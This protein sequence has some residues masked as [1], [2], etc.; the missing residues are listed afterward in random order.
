M[1]RERGETLNSNVPGA[2]DG[3]TT[4]AQIKQIMREFVDERDWRQFHK[5]KNLSMSIA[6]EAAELMEHFQWTDGEPPE[7]LQSD[8]ER[9]TEVRRELADILCFAFSLADTLEIDV[10]SAIHEKMEMNR[11]KYPADRYRGRFK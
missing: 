9:M 6:I 7:E 2:D 1:E 3:S 8:P 5:P 4:L 11:K 10:A